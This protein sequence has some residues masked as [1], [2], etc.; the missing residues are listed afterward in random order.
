MTRGRIANRNSRREEEY[1]VIWGKAEEAAELAMAT[2]LPR[3]MTVVQHSNPFDF[4][5]PIVKEY[6]V[7]EGLCGFAWVNIRPGTS[8]FARWLKK[9]GHVRADS[10]Y[11]GVTHWVSEGG[12]SI[13]RKKAYAEAMV[14]VL[15][16][17]HYDAVAMDRLD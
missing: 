14:E 2:C 12:Q 8:A 17:Y 4:T 11:G 16:E 3:P 10:Y 7:S 15:R 5:S 13:E 6:H 1:G 9:Q